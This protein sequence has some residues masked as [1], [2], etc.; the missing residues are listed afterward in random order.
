MR[1]DAISGVSVAARNDDR[2]ELQ[3]GTFKLTLPVPEA[4]RYQFV[5]VG[6]IDAALLKANGIRVEVL[7]VCSIH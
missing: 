3:T 7:A 5:L 6:G 2:L 1:P 4:G